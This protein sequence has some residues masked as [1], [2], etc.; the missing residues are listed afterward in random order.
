MTDKP[1]P[2]PVDPHPSAELAR[3]KA[4]TAANE[5][6]V[7]HHVDHRSWTLAWIEDSKA[8]IAIRRHEHATSVRRE[9]LGAAMAW[10]RDTERTGLRFKPDEDAADIDEL[11]RTAERFEAW[12]AEAGA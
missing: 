8:A 6:L 2:P 12:I 3:M 9:A 4:D 5:S 10:L 1:T 7:R 11:L